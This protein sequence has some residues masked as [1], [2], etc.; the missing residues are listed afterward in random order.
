MHVTSGQ[1][2]PALLI[3]LLLVGCPTDEPQ[4]DPVVC[5]FADEA[6]GGFV[7]APYLQSMTPTS[8]WIMW[9]TTSGHESRVD[10][11]GT[12]ELGETACGVSI[13]LNPELPEDSPTQVHEAQLTGLTPATTYRYRVTTGDAV[14]EV[15]ALRT[16]AAQAAEAPFRIVAVS[17]SQRDGSR[18]EQ[19]A[20]ILQ[21]GVLA[22]SAAEF[23]PQPE[24]ELAAILH[25]GDLVDNGWYHGQWADEFFAPGDGLFQR[26]PL[27]PVPGNHEGNS[28]HFFR[29]FHLPQNGTPGFEEHWWSHDLGNVRL[30][31]LDSNEGYRRPEQIDWLEASLDDACGDEG[32]DFVFAELHHP[33]RSEVWTPGNLDWTGEVIAAMEAF[34]TTCDKPSIHF[35]GHT[36]AYS[37]GQSRDHAHLMV[38][39][40]SA[41]GGLDRWGEQPQEDYDEFS[42]S[43]DDYGFVVVE[44]EAGDAP[45]F[46]LR[47]ISRGTPET[48]LDNVVRDDVSVRMINRPPATPTVVSTAGHDGCDGDTVLT[49][50]T[51][52]DDDG[53][54]QGAAQWQVAVGCDGFDEPVV[55]RW[56]QHENQFGGADTQAGDDL[57]DEMVPELGHGQPYCW[58]VR[59]RDRGLAWSDWSEPEA[60]ETAD[61]G[62]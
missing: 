59:Y 38:N 25:S 10:Y 57:A 53:D 37:R 9:E 7:V 52:V 47:R 32:I 41:G 21:D 49:A 14:G 3:T 17:D 35:F 60:F 33:H 34:S 5:D 42:V 44:V 13:P 51:F 43:Q 15:L 31:G 19:F 61:C 40:A 1:T 50:S 2:F 62:G 24:E 16:P 27:Y 12:E 46:R 48:P 56:R 29:Y 28:P 23:G 30:I 45:A 6:S 58:R 26:V 8:V 20:E 22:F 54:L 18:P 4:P 39:V 36:H 55:D 11:G